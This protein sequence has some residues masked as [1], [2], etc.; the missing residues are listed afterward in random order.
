MKFLSLIIL[1]SFASVTSYATEYVTQLSCSIAKAEPTLKIES[2]QN[3]CNVAKQFGFTLNYDS[4]TSKSTAQASV[5]F[6]NETLDLGVLEGA[7][8][9]SGYESEPSR[10]PTYLSIAGTPWK[11]DENGDTV[12]MSRT[13]NFGARFCVYTL[14]CKTVKQVVK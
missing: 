7:G 6:D 13:T 3:V 1:A 12:L 5:T 8:S 14:R 9:S 2:E 4:Y 11:V 10:S